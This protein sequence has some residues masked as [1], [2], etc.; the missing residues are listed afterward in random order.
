M[1]VLMSWDHNILFPKNVEKNKIYIISNYCDDLRTEYNSLPS[2]S[3]AL[4]L[5]DCTAYIGAQKLCKKTIIYIPVK[6]FVSPRLYSV[7][8]SKT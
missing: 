1:I 2:T 3:F 8:S 4:K 6:H 7:I 5:M